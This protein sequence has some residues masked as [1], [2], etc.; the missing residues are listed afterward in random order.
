MTSEIQQTLDKVN[1]VRVRAAHLTSRAQ[2]LEA[3][4]KALALHVLSEC[5]SLD[6]RFASLRAS[7]SQD[8]MRA[9]DANERLLAALAECQSKVIA[10]TQAVTTEAAALH[11]AFTAAAT[12]F[13]EEANDLTHEAAD[14][15]SW[16]S[17][18]KSAVMQ[19]A[20]V[21]TSDIQAKADEARAELNA[22]IAKAADQL[23][24]ETQKS[25]SAMGHQISETLS[26]DVRAFS[27]Q[28]SALAGKAC[29]A[30]RQVGDSVENA[31]HTDLDSLA[32]TLH[33][34]EGLLSDQLTT[35]EHSLRDL[36]VSLSEHTHDMVG[37]AK[38]A[39]DVTNTTNIGLNTVVGI[40]VDAQAIFQE[41]A[42]SL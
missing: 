14:L 24:E 18:A 36:G 27:A 10:G 12:L 6:T 11:E 13:S 25:H 34:Q 1:A 16:E 35:L 8:R 20:D 2:D 21:V 23:Y 15:R 19:R 33:D 42:K 22:A 9:S 32:S 31:V 5:A 4:I 40:V 37:G 38:A 7:V 3:E 41:V 17:S 29:D 28:L 30:I 39:N 26:A